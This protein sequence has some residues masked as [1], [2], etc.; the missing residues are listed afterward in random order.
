MIGPPLDLDAVQAFIRIAELGSFTRAAEA[1]RTT[2]AAVSSKLKRLEERLGCRLI[3]RTPRHVQL[4]TQ[5]AVFLE[6]A[7][8]LL[9]VH[10]RALA[11]F[12]GAR[13]R[14][15]IGI[16]DHVAGPELPA[17]IAR[18]NAQDPQLLIEIRIGSSGDLLQSFDRRELDTVIARLHVGRNDGEILTE[19]KFGWFASPS[20]QYRAGEPLPIATM[21]EPCGVRA[22]A[23]RLLDAAG[24]PWTEI[25]V[26]G[27]VSTVAAA[28]MAGLGVA[29]L[30]PRMLPFGAVDVGAR[31]GLPELPHLPVLLH[32]RVKNGRPRDALVALSAA[33][34]SAVR[35]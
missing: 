25:F 29:A 6:H 23:G 5:G 12:A 10:E 18:M 28:V 27:G 34:R 22:M 16:S 13:Q 20:W 3:E 30:A 21:A 32:T 1:M 31:L 8:E 26:G 14:L 19:E 11:V 24:V 9:A 7:R 17:L 33:F 4:S 15:T 2:Q 35:G